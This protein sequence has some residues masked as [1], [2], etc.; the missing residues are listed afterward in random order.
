MIR[1]ATISL[2]S[3]LVLAGCGGDEGGSATTAAPPSDPGGTTAA[4][5]APAD[6]GSTKGGT[7][8]I[9]GTTYAFTANQQCGIYDSAGQY[10]ISGDVLDVENGYLAFSRDSS[11][12]DL[13]VYIGDVGYDTWTTEDIESTISG[14]V[15]TGTASLMPD[16]PP[17]DAVPAE[18][19]FEC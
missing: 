8:T 15:I 14:N 6:P 5:G 1:N 12:H 16:A 10:Y 11:V 17:F 7:I 9:D 19:R 4:T 13:Q 18:F 2:V 3:L